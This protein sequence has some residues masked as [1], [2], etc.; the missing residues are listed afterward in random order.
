MERKFLKTTANKEITMFQYW[1]IFLFVCMPVS[2]SAQ[3]VDWEIKTEIYNG[4][5]YIVKK[6]EYTYSITNKQN[7]RFKSLTC[8]IEFEG[9]TLEQMEDRRYATRLEVYSVA[10]QIFDFENIS[11]GDLDFS[12]FH[13][14]C[15]FDST[16]KNYVGA[17][18]YFDIEVKDYFTLEKL[19]LLEQK[20]LQAGINTG[21]TNLLNPEE[22]YYTLLVGIRLGKDL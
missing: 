21:A 15:Y 22:D 17:K 12:T 10:S 5:E 16:T 6:S 1:V 14:T 11:I 20:L 19:N 2:I 4:I 9:E 18:F 3:L 8:E 7:S 13:I